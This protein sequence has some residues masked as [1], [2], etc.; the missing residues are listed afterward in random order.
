VKLVS[1]TV[2]ISAE[3]SRLICRNLPRAGRDAYEGRHGRRTTRLGPGWGNTVRT[4]RPPTR[5]RV[6]EQT[7]TSVSR[8]TIQGDTIVFDTGKAISFPFPVVQAVDYP[9]LTVVRLDTPPGSA[10]NENVFGVNDQGAVLWQVP[11]RK[12]VYAD[13]PYTGMQRQGD[14][15]VLSNWDGLEVTV[16]AATGAVIREDYGR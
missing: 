2:F 5:E 9:S 10:F 6:H 12:H 3:P 13:S 7:T 11:K 16:E 8:H 4:P 15:A 1:K 14:N